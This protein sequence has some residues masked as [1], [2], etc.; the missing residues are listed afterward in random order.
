MKKVLLF[1]LGLSIVSSGLAYAAERPF[2]LALVDPVQ[3]IDDSH[4][5]TGFRLNIFYGKNQ[6]VKGLDLGAGVGHSKAGFKGVGIH[7][8]GNFVQGDAA[9][10]Q[11]ADFVNIVIGDFTGVQLAGVNYIEGTGKGL[12]LGYV[13]LARENFSGFHIGIANITSEAHS[14]AQIG[15]FNYSG[16]PFKGF[17]LGVVNI[18]EL[19]KGLQIGLANVNT[20]K[21]P[22]VFFPIINFRF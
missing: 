5:I 15:V 3:I 4:D 18:G 2:N 22:L 6:M 12:Q 11:L 7:Y 20:S 1:V 21:K 9:G 14:G 16:G 19:E 13:Q 8:G 17:Q 10:L